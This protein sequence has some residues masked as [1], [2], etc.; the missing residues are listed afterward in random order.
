M[1]F[2]RKGYGQ[3]P[4]RT[5]TFQTKDP[6]WQNPLDKNPREH[7]RENLY[8][9]LLSGIFVLGLLKIWRGSK[10]CD[11]LWGSRDVWQSVTGG[12][13]LK[14]AKNS[15]TYFMDGPYVCMYVCV[16]VST[17]S[18]CMHVGPIV[19]LY[20][21]MYIHVY[22]VIIHIVCMYEYLLMLPD[23]SPIPMSQ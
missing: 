3:R 10:M 14:L 1:H 22:T 6:P 4:P 19:C 21:Y 5:K 15:V 17:I 20:A 7:L 23:N 8:R 11:V 16:Y 2:D 18:T 9:G 13:R 12:G